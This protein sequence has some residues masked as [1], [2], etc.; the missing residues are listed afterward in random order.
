MIRTT[1]TLRGLDLRL[2]AL[3]LVIALALKFAVH[4][5]EQ[6]TE[7]VVEAQVNY[8]PPGP[9]L[10]SY[11]LT[12]KVRVT[13]RGKASDMSQ[14]SQ[15]NVEILA[16]LPD[17]KP[18]PTAIAL[19]EQDVRF[20]TPGEF[21]VLSIDPNRFTIQVERRVRNIVPVQVELTGEPSAGAS[22]GVPTA[23]PAQ[24]QI[25]GPESKVATITHL[26]AEI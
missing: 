12:D 19:D 11:N 22:V 17:A 13:V 9:D 6:L 16:D 10:V 8:T 3:A 4:E 1:S 7:R 21:E 5:T 18:G 20:N 14:L 15:F 23:R 26:I 2:M 24:A 25:T